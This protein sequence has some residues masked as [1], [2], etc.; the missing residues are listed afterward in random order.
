[1]TDCWNQDPDERPSFQRLYKRLDAM[2]E[3]QVDYFDF[4]KKDESKYYYT[5]QE[6]KTAEVDEL[7]NPDVVSLQN[8]FPEVLQYE[9]LAIVNFCLNLNYRAKFLYCWFLRNQS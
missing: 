9:P 2:L 4:G 6:S 5:T 8:V 1:M 7:D 3:E